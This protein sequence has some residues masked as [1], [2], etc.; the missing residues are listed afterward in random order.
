[1]DLSLK[2][3]HFL[4]LALGLELDCSIGLKIG[5]RSEDALGV[6]IPN[7]HSTVIV[8][9]RIRSRVRVRFQRRLWCLNLK[10]TFVIC[11]VTISVRFVRNLRRLDSKHTFVIYTVRIWVRFDQIRICKKMFETNYY[12]LSKFT[13]C[14]I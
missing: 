9:V 7:P 4:K 1:M 14:F 11:T 3:T 2:L 5:L 8:K 13:N 12:P 6:W 10:H